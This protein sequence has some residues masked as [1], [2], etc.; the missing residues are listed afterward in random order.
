MPRDYKVYLR[1]ILE[2]TERIR[3]YTA[4]VSDFARDERTMDAVLRNLEVIGEAAKAIPP[5]FRQAHPE[6]EWKKLAGMRDVLIHEYFGV[7]AAI[8]RDVVKNKLPGLK[9]SIRG[10]LKGEGG[11]K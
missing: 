10:I 11:R 8:I 6:V 3:R 1:D 4:G 9:R 2:A 5:A 7:D